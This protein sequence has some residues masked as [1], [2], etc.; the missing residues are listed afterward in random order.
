[1]QKI[2]RLYNKKDI[3]GFIFIFKCPYIFYYNCVY[4]YFRKHERL[5]QSFYTDFAA[6]PV[7]IRNNIFNLIKLAFRNPINIITHNISLLFL[8]IAFSLFINWNWINDSKTILVKFW[9]MSP[10]VFF[11][12][13]KSKSTIPKR[14]ITFLHTIFVCAV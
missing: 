7:I 6:M 9:K 4:F 13:N 12:Y 1:M 2:Y 10:L 14:N 3:Q 11:N 5:V 8:C